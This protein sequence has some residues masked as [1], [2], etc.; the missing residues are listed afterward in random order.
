MQMATKRNNQTGVSKRAG[1]GR[2]SGGAKAG[3]FNSFALLDEDMAPA[4][5][6]KNFSLGPSLIAQALFDETKAFH[7]NNPFAE[8]LPGDEFGGQADMAARPQAHEGSYGHGDLDDHGEALRTAAASSS[9][10]SSSAAAGAGV[11]VDPI[12]AIR[13]GFGGSSASDVFGEAAAMSVGWPNGGKG[14]QVAGFGFDDD[15]DAAAMDFAAVSQQ[16]KSSAARAGAGKTDGGG[17]GGGETMWDFSGLG[18][19]AEEVKKRAEEEEAEKKAREKQ[20]AF[21]A[22]LSSRVKTLSK[23]GDA[24]ELKARMAKQEL[25]HKQRVRRVMEVSRGSSFA[26]RFNVRLGKQ[27]SKRKQR[28]KVKHL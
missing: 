12:A 19:T 13:K 24:D 23:A 14:P 11:P 21:E 28:N 10:S 22:N 15:A 18:L 8:K 27:D 1:L 3:T 4:S 16:L 5:K 26:E 7:K 20:E 25:T 2:G 6:K 9:S 17:A